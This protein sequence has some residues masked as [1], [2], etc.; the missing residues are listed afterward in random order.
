MWRINWKNKVTGETGN[1][2]PLCS[3]AFADSW[4]SFLNDQYPHV[5]HWAEN[6]ADEHCRACD[7]KFNT[8]SCK[9]KV[10]GVAVECY[11]HGGE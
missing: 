6:T 10:C 9:C 5:D 1:S 4:A 7:E 3:W 8:N 2:Q 11:E